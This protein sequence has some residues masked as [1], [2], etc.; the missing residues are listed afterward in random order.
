ML[1][2]PAIT[3]GGLGCL[4]ISQNKEMAQ[5]HF[6]MV[7]RAYKLIGAEDPFNTEANTFSESLKANLLHTEYSNRRELVFDVLDSKVLIASAEVE[8]AA[9]GITLHHIVA[10]E[11]SRWPGKPDETLSNVMGALAPGGT[12][13]KEATANMAVGPYF[14]DFVRAMEEPEK[15]PA[16][17]FFFESYWSD[18]YSLPLSAKQTKELL[19]DLRADEV[20]LIKKMHKELQAVAWMRTQYVRGSAA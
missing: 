20:H 17:A 9:Q 4:L 12:L 18:E 1:L 8:E 16:K 3:E 5:E 14:E 15:S 2:L 13:D 6:A 19:A 11:Y 10:S 7:R